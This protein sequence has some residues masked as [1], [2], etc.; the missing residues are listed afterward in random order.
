MFNYNDQPNARIK[1]IMIDIMAVLY[2]NGIKEAQVGILMRLLGVTDE[3]ASTHDNESI[4]LY[5]NFG[6]LLAHLN[7]QVPPIIPVGTIFH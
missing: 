5:E 3:D 6:Q 4:V 2:K 7:K 1:E